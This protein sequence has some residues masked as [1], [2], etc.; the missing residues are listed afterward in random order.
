MTR[1][2]PNQR[3]TMSP[4]KTCEY[5]QEWFQSQTNDASKKTCEYDKDGPNHRPMM[6]PR[7]H[8][9]MAR[10]GSGMVPITDH[11]CHPENM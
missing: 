2:G 5:G 8:V 1:N 10:N 6:P 9:N 7:K 4:R 3:P 11:R